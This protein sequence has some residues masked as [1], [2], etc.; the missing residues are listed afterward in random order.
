MSFVFFLMR[1]KK[2]QK[3]KPWK[4]GITEKLN[5]TSKKQPEHEVKHWLTQIQ[6]IPRQ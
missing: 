3:F 6:Y 1:K 2:H 4:T 5:V